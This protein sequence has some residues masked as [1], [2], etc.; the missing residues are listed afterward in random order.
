MDTHVLGDC[1]LGQPQAYELVYLLNLLR[2]QLV[3][4]RPST[5]CLQASSIGMCVVLRR[6]TP[7]KVLSTIVSLNA[8][9]VIHV[10]VDVGVW[11]KVGRY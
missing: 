10:P 6:C 2:S 4:R 11:D 5:R 3:G 8:V 1:P 7:L 9:Y